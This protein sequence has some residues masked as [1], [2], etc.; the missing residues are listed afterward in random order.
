MGDEDYADFFQFEVKETS[1]VDL[2]LSGLSADAALA[3]Y[4]DD[5]ED[6]ELGGLKL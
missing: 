2:G 1:I 6:G 3:L 5:N 4:K